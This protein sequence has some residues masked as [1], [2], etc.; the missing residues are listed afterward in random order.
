MGG[1][2][3]KKNG[4]GGAENSRDMWSTTECTTT[5]IKGVQREKKKVQKDL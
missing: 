1:K 4:V 3:K 5:N 2:K